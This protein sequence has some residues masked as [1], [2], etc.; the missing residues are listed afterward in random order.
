[1]T[2]SNPP[3]E[4]VT[5][6]AVV[7]DAQQRIWIFGGFRFAGRYQGRGP[8][9]KAILSSSTSGRKNKTVD[10]HLCDFCDVILR[11]QRHIL[12]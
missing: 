1:V 3:A 7:I 6:S 11:I 2:A 5:R 12:E 8:R 4:R 9:V 10:Q